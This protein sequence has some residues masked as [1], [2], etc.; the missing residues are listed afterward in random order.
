MLLEKMI[1]ISE[2]TEDSF[3]L[4]ACKL[5]YRSGLQILKYSGLVTPSKYLTNLRICL[6]QFYCYLC[7]IFSLHFLCYLYFWFVCKS[8]SCKSEKETTFSCYI[9]SGNFCCKYSS[10]HCFVQ[11]WD[12]L[13]FEHHLP[14]AEVK[15]D[16]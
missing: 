2:I 3:C 9:N 16:A 14:G 11:W 10:W 13:Q 5:K 12:T 7:N 1:N 15:L 6:E 4:I 8:N